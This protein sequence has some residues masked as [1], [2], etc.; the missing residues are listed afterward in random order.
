MSRRISLCA[1]LFYQKTARGGQTKKRG[2]CRA[3]IL[4]PPLK[5]SGPRSARPKKK[6]PL[7]ATIPRKVSFWRR[8]Q[9]SNL[10][11]DCSHTRFPSVRL[12]PL[13]HLS[14]LLI[15]QAWS[16]SATPP[17]GRIVIAYPRHGL[18]NRHRQF[19]PSAT[20]PSLHAYLCFLYFNRDVVN[21]TLKQN[22]VRLWLRPLSGL[23]IIDSTYG[24]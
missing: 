10:R 1:L 4:I 14:I 17:V 8:E 24:D 12:Q 19:S 7:R 2:S 5:T 16:R 18:A 20:R 6:P 23:L 21:A 9:D 3:Q 13:G 22:I 11:Y 15:V